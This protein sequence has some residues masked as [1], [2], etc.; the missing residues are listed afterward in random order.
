MAII[1]IAIIAVFLSIILVIDIFSKKEH[2][3]E[4]IELQKYQEENIQEGKTKIFIEC[5]GAK[6]AGICAKT[7]REI[8][9]YLNQGYKI[10]TSQLVFDGYYKYTYTVMIKE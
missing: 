9:R 1:I 2:E 8:N 4:E 3:N 10:I 5:T 7:E 6:S